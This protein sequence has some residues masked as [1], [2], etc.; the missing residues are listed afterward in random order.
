MAA[1]ASATLAS[2]TS[3]PSAADWPHSPRSSHRLQRDQAAPPQLRAARPAATGPGGELHRPVHRRGDGAGSALQGPNPPPEHPGRAQRASAAHGLEGSRGRQGRK[4]LADGEHGGRGSV[5]DRRATED[6]ARTPGHP[7][8]GP[9]VLRGGA[10]AP[11]DLPRRV[12]S[13]EGS[14]RPPA[15]ARR[16]DT[17]RQQARGLLLR[18]LVQRSRCC[19]AD[20]VSASTAIVSS[21]ISL[22]ATT[23]SRHRYARGG[24]P[25]SLRDQPTPLPDARR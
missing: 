12:R 10:G 6:R 4:G 19:S 24:R 5:A 15:P 1:L 21:R 20:G 13:G 22:G 23:L 7:P 14:G 2:A 16:V 8:R 17:R 25:C 9:S 18:G 3:P 11:V